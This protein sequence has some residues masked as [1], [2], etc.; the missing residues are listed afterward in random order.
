VKNE[1]IVGVG[2][3]RGFRYC[4][5]SAGGEPYMIGPNQYLVKSLFGIGGDKKNSSGG[6]GARVASTRVG[7]FPSQVDKMFS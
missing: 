3:S 2:E 5:K 7:G 6:S 1:I 4:S